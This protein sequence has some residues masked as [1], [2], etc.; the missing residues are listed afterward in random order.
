MS[1]R[2]KGTE[3]LFLHRNCKLVLKLKSDSNPPE[4]ITGMFLFSESETAS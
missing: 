3:S 2:H 4:L 1:Q